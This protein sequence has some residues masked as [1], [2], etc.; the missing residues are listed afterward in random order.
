MKGCIGYSIR[1]HLARLRCSASLSW[2]AAW[3]PAIRKGTRDSIGD[4]HRSPN[5]CN[6]NVLMSSLHPLR[7]SRKKKSMSAKV[8]SIFSDDVS[9]WQAL[10]LST[11]WAE[12]RSHHEGP[13]EPQLCHVEAP[14]W[15]LLP[16]R[17]SPSTDR[18]YFTICQNELKAD[19]G[20]KSLLAGTGLSWLVLS[21]HIGSYLVHIPTRFTFTMW[22]LLGLFVNEAL[23]AVAIF[24]RFSSE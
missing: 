18:I 22:D 5:R 15:A 2:P 7:P 9:C 10:C 23:C 21:D 13:V 14:G 24:D 20:V 1:V 11:S 16:D 6:V 12:Q 17:L 19:L 4:L 8:D 3:N